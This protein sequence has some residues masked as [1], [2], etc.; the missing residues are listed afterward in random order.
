MAQAFAAAGAA[1]SARVYAEHVRRAWRDAD[2]ELV[3]LLADLP[4]R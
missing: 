1:D 4:T 3:S 2:P